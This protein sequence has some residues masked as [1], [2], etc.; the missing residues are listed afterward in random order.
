MILYL[1]RHGETDWNV[2]NR[3]QGTLDVPLNEKGRRLAR[4][5]G[6]GMKE[7]PFTAAFA[8]ELSRSYE[9]AGLILQHNASYR[10]NAR[11]FLD[12]LKEAEKARAVETCG[13]SVLRDER[14]HEIDLGP[15]TGRFAPEL[16]GKGLMDY[17]EDPEGTHFPEGLENANAL[18]LRAEAFLKDVLARPELRDRTV[19]VV[20]HGGFLRALLRILT[21][22]EEF[23][24][25]LFRNC[26][27]A[28]FELDEKGSIVSVRKELFYDPEL[29][30][31]GESY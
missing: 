2:T 4:L 19:L 5:T 6:E 11:D 26:E 13:V 17:W 15:W 22:G 12:G 9:T 7:I 28:I 14:L 18:L 27:T 29:A 24:S 31:Q 21:G 30:L 1:L 8:S 10:E 3:L 20:T 23:G 16:P 25:V